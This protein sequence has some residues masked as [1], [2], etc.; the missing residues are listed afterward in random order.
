MGGNDHPGRSDVSAHPAHGRAK[1]L[2]LCRDWR[3]PR[4]FGIEPPRPSIEAI[5]TVDMSGSN[6]WAEFAS[7]YRLTRPAALD[8]E[9]AKAEPKALV[10]ED[11]NE[12]S[13]HGMRVKR[14]K[15]GTIN[16]ELLAEEASHAALQR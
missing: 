8:H 4:L 14:S 1:I 16:L 5:R 15:S 2:A 7:L 10:P 11:V 9:R 6:V 12:V 13:G 3:A